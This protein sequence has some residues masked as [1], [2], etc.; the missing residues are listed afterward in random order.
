MSTTKVAL[1]LHQIRRMAAE[2]TSPDGV[3]LE[4]FTRNADEAAFNALMLRHGPLVWSVS[5]RGTRHEQDAEDVY[6]ATFLLLAR[7]A[8]S[9]RKGGSVSSWLYGVAHRLALR[10]RSD[11]ARQRERENQATPVRESSGPDDLTVR[12]LREV[13][14]DELARLPDKYWAPLLLCYFEGMTHE[15][16]SRQLGW[17]PRSVKDRLERGRNRLR[18]R[19]AKRGVTLSLTLAGSMLTGG[20]ATAAAPPTLVEKTLR[21]AVTFAAGR[22]LDGI[23]RA[24]ALAIAAGGLRTMLVTKLCSLAFVGTALLVLGSA[25]LLIHNAASEDFV[26]GAAN[27]PD[28]SERIVDRYGDPLPRGAV[29]RLGTVRYRFANTAAAFLADGKTVVSPQGNGSSIILWWDAR[30]G[31]AV[32]E[33]DT[34]QFVIGG[35][36]GSCFSRARSRIALTGSITDPLKPGWRFAIRVY[37]AATGKEVRHLEPESNGGDCGIALTPD[38]KTLVHSDRTGTLRVVDLETGAERLQQK[39]PRDIG[40]NLAFSPDGSTL[41]LASGPNTNKLYLWKWQSGE[42]PRELPMRDHHG[43]GLTFSPDGRY[44]AECGD[45]ELAVQVWDAVQG[46]LLHR[47]DVPDGEPFWHHGLAFSP[48]GK[49]LAAAA[50][51]ND[52]HGC[53]HLWEP[54]SGKFLKRLE[55]GGS[56]PLA[57]SPDS[58]LLVS[59]SSVWDFTKDREL[60][61]LEG[62]PRGQMDF[63]A[64]AA[65][66]IATANGDGTILV[67]DPAT[68][69]VQTQ[70]PR[71]GDIHALALS[72]DGKRLLTSHQEGIGVWDTTTGKRM[73]RLNGLSKSNCSTQSLAFSPD[74]K[75]FLEWGSDMA[76]RKW[77]LGTGKAA[78]EKEIRPGGVKILEEDDPK[79]ELEASFN[80]GRLTR[81]GK[82]LILHASTQFGWTTY[83]LNSETGKQQ[84]SITTKLGW[85]NSSVSSH[86]GKRILASAQDASQI[87]NLPGGGRQSAS[88]KHH[89]ILV[90]DIKTGDEQLRLTL[91]DEYSGPVAFSADDRII[92]TASSR[93]GTT[94]RLLD[95]ATGREVRKI[96]GFKGTVRSLAFMPDGKRL[97]SGMSDSSALI[98]DLTRER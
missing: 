77:D 11:A 13:L 23:V 45:V 22:P 20:L 93:P 73:Y 19:L 30:T 87:V 57:F 34:G 7:K 2:P 17:T 61:A 80:R 1:L 48:D 40:S 44:F 81:D 71:K 52:R 14:D 50:N 58:T 76:V 42:K 27:P 37:D 75:S 59:G 86:D 8:C 97:V 29:A 70:I 46:K 35:G 47:L 83:V 98:W 53:I 41:A 65:D 60:A 72:A 18:V 91:P 26:P 88:P 49:M 94:I 33:I 38:G 10:A 5:L 96:E 67:W 4:R 25:G 64:T 15:E 89:L 90:W 69:K 85:I 28:D 54:A 79:A 24:G 21:A 36:Y 78:S 95:A 56:V 31:R 16:A 68:G 74:M 82:D 84:Q 92:V 63:I 39:F 55:F 32:R 9:I 6:Q 62:S 12:E 66:V 43:V 3:L 51:N